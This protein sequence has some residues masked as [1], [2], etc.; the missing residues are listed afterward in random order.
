MRVGS[1][2]YAS[3]KDCPIVDTSEKYLRQ[4]GTRGM[5][6]KRAAMPPAQ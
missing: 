1:K 2:G 3:R 4:W 5:K 6:K